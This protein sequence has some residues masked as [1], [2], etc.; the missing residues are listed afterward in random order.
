MLNL[1]NVGL[2]KK[3]TAIK[4]KATKER[5]ES[6]FSNIQV[7]KSLDE[8]YEIDAINDATQVKKTVPLQRVIRLSF[9]VLTASQGRLF[10]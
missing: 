6:T 5:E 3:Y 7:A 10:S 9:I 1:I 8:K 4:I 2:E